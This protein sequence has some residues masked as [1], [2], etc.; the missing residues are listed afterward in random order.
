[1]DQPTSADVHRSDGSLFHRLDLSL[2][3]ADIDHQCADDR[4][5]GRYRVL[6]KDRFAVVWHVTG[7]RKRY[8]LATLY[9]R[10]GE[11]SR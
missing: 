10:A 2:G 9:E 6:G 7:P 11:R 5:R 1:M 3:T 8:R 4:Y